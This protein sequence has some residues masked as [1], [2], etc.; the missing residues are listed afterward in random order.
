MTRDLV[1]AV[2]AV[3]LLGLGVRGGEPSVAEALWAHSVKASGG[4]LSSDVFIDAQ[5]ELAR[6]RPWQTGYVRA[7]ER[8]SR[9]GAA[10]ST[11]SPTRR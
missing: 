10:R 7:R 1:T 11:W 3:V 6:I 9:I 4:D 2:I 8:M 5:R